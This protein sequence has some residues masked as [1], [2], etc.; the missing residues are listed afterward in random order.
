MTNL[1]SCQ[2]SI[3]T[4]LWD[5]DIRRWCQDF[6]WPEIW[7]ICK[8]NSDISA[9]EICELINVNKK[10]DDCVLYNQ[11]FFESHDAEILGRDYLKQVSRLLSNSSS[12]LTNNLKSQEFIGKIKKFIGNEK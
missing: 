8:Q 12:Y 2:Y 3:R 4:E 6:V 1:R 5:D 11:R 9:N 7:M 10:F